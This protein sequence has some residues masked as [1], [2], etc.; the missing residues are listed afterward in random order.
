[1]SPRLV[2]PLLVALGAGLLGAIIAAIASSRRGRVS[3]RLQELKTGGTA[4]A[5]AESMKQLAR[6]ALPKLGTHLMPTDTKERT[7]LQA[8][9]VQAGLYGRQAMVVFL[10]VKMLLMVGPALIG[11]LIGL[12]GIAPMK[13]AAL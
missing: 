12:A 1:M 6:A 11:A 4:S 9:L 2:L 10:G 13:P 7:R 5:P 8:R 3:D